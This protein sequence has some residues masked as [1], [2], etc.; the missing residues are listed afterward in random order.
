MLTKTRYCLS[1]LALVI[2]A[3]GCGI[4]APRT[5]WGTL[6]TPPPGPRFYE[7][8]ELGGHS[9]SYS[10]F[11]RNGI[12]YTC[13]AGHID[14]THLR[15]SAD[16]TRYLVNKTR[17]TL[18][19]KDRVFT[20]SVSLESSRHRVEF[21]YP[22]YWDSLSHRQ[23]ERVAEVIAFR[24][25]PYLAYNALLWHEILTWFGVHFI[26]VEPEFNSSFSWEDIYSNLLG[27]KIAVEALKDTKHSYNR[28]V[29]LAIDRNL[30]EL[31]VQ[32]KSVAI[33]A[34]EKMR[35]KWYTGILNVNMIRRN[36]DTGLDD[37]F[38][39]PVIV[40]GICYG[41]VPRP[42]AVPS[43]AILSGYGFSMKHEI[44]PYEWERDEILRAVYPD[45]DGEV[46]EPVKHFAR[47]MYYIKKQAAEKYN[48][49]VD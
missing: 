47:L 34:S 9:Y 8:N 6:P 45:G 20:F 17:S 26:G 48:Y 32:P 38:V 35:G 31:G 33:D 22:E 7:L 40:P 3:N 37:G 19:Q 16:Y 5:R 49:I 23:K 46:V 1:V 15:W 13:K 29:T 41:A 30:K 18:M 24:I 43:I 28:A 4:N 36:M 10:P 25:G 2:L 11:E 21:D 44:Y 39:T 42:L 12:V 14:V 27:T